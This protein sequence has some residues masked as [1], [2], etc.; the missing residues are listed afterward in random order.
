MDEN[1]I[2]EAEALEP[3]VEKTPEQL[4]FERQEEER[5]KKAKVADVLDKIGNVCLVL[6]A[7]SP[8]AIIGYILWF[9]ITG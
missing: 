6:L 3:V 8:F 9:F 7:L 2:Q 1:M 4:E 5:L